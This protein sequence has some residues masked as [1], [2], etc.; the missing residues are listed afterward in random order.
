[1]DSNNRFLAVAFYEP[2]SPIRLRIVSREAGRAVDEAFWKARFDS[3]VEMRKHAFDDE[4]TNGYRLIHGE[5]EGWPGLVLDRYAE[6][7]VLKLYS[8]AW[9]LL[10]PTLVELVRGVGVE[11][12]VLRMSRNLAEQART[13]PNF[14]ELR[15]PGGEAT[16][17]VMV[18]DGIV[19]SGPPVERPVVFRENG[20]LFEADVLRGQKTGFF[21]D[22]RDNRLFTSEL[23]PM[24][25]LLNVFSFSGG[26]SVYAAAAG[27]ASVTNLDISAHALAS[28]ERNLKL[29]ASRP[30]VA[31]CKLHQ[32]QADAF[33]WLEQRG[34]SYDVVVLDPPSL[35]KR[36]QERGRALEAYKRLAVLGAARVRPGGTLVAASC[37]AHVSQEEFFSAV[38]QSLSGTRRSF[39]ELSRT[40]HPI[41]HPAT[42]REAQYLKCIY[43]QM[44]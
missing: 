20:L 9:F 22:Q 24:K 8:A 33:E 11:R 2:A 44:D 4:R 34:P 13:I 3:C 25:D 10:L 32:V 18:E 38:L 26:F 35:A 21:L 12:V 15:A 29:N 1:Y 36:E 40:G 31:A 7:G 19:L 17:G 43:L 28:A 41:D 37:S 14:K 16:P 23:R 27:A 42:F 39:R 30:A 6:T 5:S